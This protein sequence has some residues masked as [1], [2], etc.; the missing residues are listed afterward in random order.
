MRGQIDALSHARQSITN[1]LSFSVDM[2]A[3]R[4][5]DDPLENSNAEILNLLQQVI[6][7]NHRTYAAIRSNATGDAANN[8]TKVLRGFIER[9]SSMGIIPQGEVET[10]IT[11]YTSS[12]HDRWV[13]SLLTRLTPPLGSSHSAGEFHDDA[14]PT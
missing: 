14:A 7:T 10:L 1:P 3:L 13:N 11:D 9:L 12:A 6:S 5:S 2:Q 4:K 8:D